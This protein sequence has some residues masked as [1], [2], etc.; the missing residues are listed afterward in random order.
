M[1]KKLTAMERDAILLH[2]VF[3]VLCTIVLVLPI[4]L[5][6]GIKMLFLVLFY[7]IVTPIIGT[8]YQRKEWFDI[9]VFVFITSL[10]QVMPDW[11]LSAQLNVLDFPDDGIFKI[12]DVSGYMAGLWAIPLFIIIFTGKRIRDRFSLSVTLWTVAV[13]SLLIFA[14]SEETM[15]I[16]PSWKAINVTQIGHIAVYLIIPEIILG[17]SAYLSYESIQGRNYWLKIPAAFVVMLLY[18]GSLSIFY[19]LIE[20]IILQS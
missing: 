15:W 14:G 4:N 6:V 1:F 2:L 7:N 18:T 20:K 3:A 19:F 12:G 10:F 13:L 16:I 9:W 8:R 5:S 11:Y 17:L